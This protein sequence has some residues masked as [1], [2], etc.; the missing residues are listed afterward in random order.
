MK[1]LNSLSAILILSLTLDPLVTGQMAHA[2]KADDFHAACDKV[3][4]QYDLN[5]ADSKV[6]G[7]PMDVYAE[8]KDAELALKKKRVQTTKTIIY[9]AAAASCTALIYVTWAGGDA[10]CSAISVATAASDVVTDQIFKNDAKSSMQ[11]V[12]G[13]LNGAEGAFLLKEG[14]KALKVF[15][16]GFGKEAGKATGD[17]S[18]TA[19]K[20]TKVKN[21]GCILDAAVN[22]AL[23]AKAGIE[24]GIA[25]KFLTEHTKASV[26]LAEG[27]NQQTRIDTRYGTQAH[28]SVN[29]AVDNSGSAAVSNSGSG[30]GDCD[31]KSGSAFLQC[32]AQSTND[33]QLSAIASSGALDKLLSP[34]L[35]QSLGDFVKGYSGDGSPASAANYAA[36]ALGM[37]AG[38]SSLVASAIDKFKDVAGSLPG[39]EHGAGY[40]S[41]SQPAPETGKTG[42][43]DFNK[44]MGDLLKQM[45]PEAAKETSKENAAEAVYRK[46]DLLPADKIEANKD[47]SL[48]ARVGYRYRKKD[49]AFNPSK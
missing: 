33:P 13:L 7:P 42:E 4:N 12:T 6:P 2:N 45:N 27:H 47:I 43:M 39:S 26:K 37:T 30:G 34:A 15:Q 24:L 40:A 28:G 19:S 17:A 44:L 9:T 31:S 49:Q 25:Q 20:S 14:P 8:C 16:K 21:S 1:N 32:Q 18:K 48:F 10:M 23:A 46:L 3:L 29:A 22:A 38:G 11:S 36:N 41:A 35:G 5:Q